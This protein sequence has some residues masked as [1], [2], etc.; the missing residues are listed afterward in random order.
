MSGMSAHKQRP[1]Y[2]AIWALYIM[3]CVLYGV[4]T[5]LSMGI[6]FFAGSAIL[7]YI[8][9]QIK[10]A[11]CSDVAML[12]LL[13]ILL[14]ISFRSIFCTGY[15]EIPLPWFYLL[16]LIM[17]IREAGK[18]GKINHNILAI[19]FMLA[20]CIIPL[21]L[22]I[23]I[24]EGVKEYLGYASFF[25][26][27][28]VAYFIKRRRSM[29]LTDSKLLFAFYV[30]GAIFA[31]I[32]IILQYIAY[33]YL[34]IDL[35]HIKRYGGNRSLLMFLFYDMS[36]NTIYL[37]SAVVLRLLSKCKTRYL[38]CFLI[39]AAMA[40]T[41]ARSGIVCLAILLVMMIVFAKRK[42]VDKAALLC[43]TVI[44]CMAGISIL[45]STRSSF[46]SVLDII[47]FDNR[48]SELNIAALQWFSRSPL[49]GCGL[50]LGKQMYAQGL[51]V[52]HFALISLLAQTGVIISAGFCA[53]LLSIYRQTRKCSIEALKWVFLLCMGGSCI[54]PSFFDLR[55]F[56]FICMMGILAPTE[57][58]T[59][60]QLIRR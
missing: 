10:K 30:N 33:R 14:P 9:I 55:F 4:D 56:T 60:A 31:S 44:I 17:F 23:S 53:L 6:G 46:S 29:T 57:R 49:F 27:C 1:I 40:L 39:A 5:T 41:S 37:G 20:L 52:P 19:L 42:S 47:F 32:G 25:V 51:M 38:W 3:N 50:D 54:A 43:F 36:G 35:F 45:M 7:L 28:M 12:A 15:A 26:G 34:S 48:R 16:L 18:S 22:S 11:L 8:Y 24:V 59:Y 2:V 21:M 13:A 58:Q